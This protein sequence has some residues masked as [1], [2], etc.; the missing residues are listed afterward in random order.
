M[1][2]RTHAHTLPPPTDKTKMSV[3][4]RRN[5]CRGLGV[6]VC[7]LA[8]CF[9]YKV[10]QKPFSVIDPTQSAFIADTLS[11][12]SFHF[13]PRP[14]YCLSHPLLKYDNLSSILRCDYNFV[15]WNAILQNGLDRH[16]ELVRFY[17][18]QL[19]LNLLVMF[20]GHS[21]KATFLWL[22]G[23]YSLLSYKNNNNLDI[24]T[25]IFLSPFICKK[26]SPKKTTTPS[27]VSLTL[28]TRLLNP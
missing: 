16:K 18:L 26:H 6:V 11:P 4:S 3:Q 1:H 17:H 8:V 19:H 7:P 25:I 24:S 27:D 13:G 21:D 15:P 22:L 23:W 20:Q 5:T 2:T 12:N 9:I 28:I 14:G 10:G